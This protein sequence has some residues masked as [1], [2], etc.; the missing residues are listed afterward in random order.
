M[1]SSMYDVANQVMSSMIAQA[2]RWMDTL[3]IDVVLVSLFDVAEAFAVDVIV[4]LCHYLSND[5]DENAYAFD[6]LLEFVFLLKFSVYDA[7]DICNL[8]VL[9]CEELYRKIVREKIGREEKW[10]ESI[11]IEK[12]CLISSELVTFQV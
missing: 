1:E 10:N 3:V 9:S 6:D 4:F 8:G 5:D 7:A 2:K 12:N 11:F